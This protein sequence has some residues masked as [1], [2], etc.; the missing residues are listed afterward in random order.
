MPQHRATNFREYILLREMDEKGNGSEKK[1]GI[2]SSIVLGK[3]N[4]FKPFIVTDDN[5]NPAY[6]SNKNLAPIVRAFQDS[7]K[8]KVYNSI[9]KDGE[10][11]PHT[12]GSKTLYM[13]GGAVRDHLKGKTPHDIDLATDAS[14]DEIRM[15]LSDNGFKELHKDRSGASS[16][17]G[18]VFYVKGKDKAGT[19]F[20]FGVKVGGQEFELATFRKDSHGSDGRFPDQMS[21][22]G[23]ADDAARRDLTINS[24]YLL[25]NNPDGPNNQITDFHGGVH[26]LEG[27]NVKFV[28]KAEDRLEEDLLRAL[29]YARFAARFGGGKID[30]E[31]AKKIKEVAPKIRNVIS[32]ERI[33]QEFVKGLEN[34]DTDPVKLVQIYKQLGLLEVVFPGMSIKLDT[35]EDYPK[36]RDRAVVV[37]SLLRGNHPSVIEKA[38]REGKW[39]N[40]DITRVAFLHKILSLHPN[41]N[42]DDLDGFLHGYNRSGIMGRSVEAWWN[43]NKKGNPEL[44]RAFLDFAKNPRVKTTLLDDETGDEKMNPDFSHLFNPIDNNPLPGM[45]Q[46]IGKLKRDKEHGNFLDL[47]RSYQ[48]RAKV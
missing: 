38:L 36:D 44:L 47:Y 35:L 18:K 25:L 23:H 34:D 42:A 15:I 21:F 4:G 10:A 19:D 30:P 1:P 5:R 32:P 8:V 43:H 45:G 7:K 31:V 37:A 3:D 28:G 24:L 12:L 6:P 48:P 39:K 9:S 13:V 29:R 22:G 14:P 17:D 41:M 33:Q 46:M 26:D 11:K 40:E 27:G 2:T 16:P 20:V